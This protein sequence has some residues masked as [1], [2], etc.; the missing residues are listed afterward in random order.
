VPVP[1]QD[2]HL[3]KP[4]DPIPAQKSTHHDLFS[5]GIDWSFSVSASLV[6]EPVLCPGAGTA[7]KS[8]ETLYSKRVNFTA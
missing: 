5:A 3:L 1:E 8:Q 6:P 7:E 4:N 2:Q